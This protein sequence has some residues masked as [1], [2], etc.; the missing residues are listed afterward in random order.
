MCAIIK[1]ILNKR[2]NQITAPTTEPIHWAAPQEKNI[3]VL[4]RKPIFLT[5]SSKTVGFSIM[6]C[7]IFY[8]STLGPNLK[9]DIPIFLK[10]KNQKVCFNSTFSAV[11]YLMLDYGLFQVKIRIKFI[12][13]CLLI[14]RVWK[15][16]KQIVSEKTHANSGKI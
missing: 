1:V 12:S 15:T 5:I 14:I 11:T 10:I 8:S 6:I 9:F 16:L 4:L 3:T 2:N 7:D 13:G